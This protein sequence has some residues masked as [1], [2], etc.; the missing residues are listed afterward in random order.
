MMP[1][2]QLDQGA[3]ILL[4]LGALVVATPLVI[5]WLHARLKG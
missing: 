4:L 3:A 2:A 1:L 5:W